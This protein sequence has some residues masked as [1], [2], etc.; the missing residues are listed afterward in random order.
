MQFIRICVVSSGSYT[1]TAGISEIVHRI[2]EFITR[3]D[4]GT[5]SYPEN[6]YISPGSQWSLEVTVNITDILSKSL[7]PV[8]HL[9][10][11]IYLFTVLLRTFSTSW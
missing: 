8:D 3:R 11:N 10:V 7:P 2:S 1:A 5:P 6:I 9:H 4:R